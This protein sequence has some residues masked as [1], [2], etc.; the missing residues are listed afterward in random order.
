[1]KAETLGDSESLMREIESLSV[2]I[3]ELREQRNKLNLEAKT[4]LRKGENLVDEA[5]KLKRELRDLREE[6]GQLKAEI[7]Q[8]KTSLEKLRKDLAEKREVRDELREKLRGL[9]AK[10]SIPR[11]KAERLFEELEWQIQTNPLSPEEERKLVERVKALEGQLDLHGKISLLIEKLNSNFQEIQAL[12]EEI[13]KFKEKLDEVYGKL[14]EKLAVLS[15]KSKRLEEA[16]REAKEAYQKFT[17]AKVQAD[18]LH[19]RIVEALN[20]QRSLKSGLREF[21]REKEAEALEG[22]VKELEEAYKQG[23]KKKLTL[24]EFKLLM[25]RG[26]I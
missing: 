12:R 14:K 5:R 19:R 22:V 3:V 9:K 6:V 17:N 23:K 21:K 16:E 11:G 26:L 20:K 13:G 2:E 25:S 4:W 18:R 10:V 1:M 24:E 7:R 8:L 15:E